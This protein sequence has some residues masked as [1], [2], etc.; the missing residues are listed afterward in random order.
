MH[1][2][3]SA[4]RGCAARALSSL[5]GRGSPGRTPGLQA[6]ALHGHIQATPSGDSGCRQSRGPSP[7]GS[8]GRGWVLGGP[9][10]DRDR[11]MAHPPAELWAV[12][13]W[14][15]WKRLSSAE[16]QRKV[17]SKPC[18]A[19]VLLQRLVGFTMPRTMWVVPRGR[20]SAS[21]V[22]AAVAV[23][24]PVVVVVVHR[25]DKTRQKAVGWK[26][27]VTSRQSIANGAVSDQTKWCR[28]QETAGETTHARARMKLMWLVRKA[29]QPHS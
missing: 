8:P 16:S 12:I 18:F 11:G 24:R 7:G 27:T 29:L 2:V 15:T 14:V 25:D 20:G 13:F 26:A 28:K 3:R 4:P 9:S 22:V 19:K 10:P 21:V 5:Y 23:A 6:T 17:Q 1:R